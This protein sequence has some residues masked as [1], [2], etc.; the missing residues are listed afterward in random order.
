VRPASIKTIA[1]RVGYSRNTVSLALRNDRRVTDDTRQRVLTAA[2]ELNYRPNL[3]ARA[4]VTGRSQMLGLAIPRLDFSYMPRLVESIQEAAFE[5]GYGV[6]SCSHHNERHRLPELLSYL[7]DRQVEGVIVYC[8]T[9][10]ETDIAHDLVFPAA[11]TPLVSF[12]FGPQR[13]RGLELDLLP[14]AAGEMAVRHFV[15]RG[16]TTIGYC[17][18]TDGFFGAARLA[19]VRR[20]LTRRKLKPPAVFD[21]RDSIDGGREAARLFLDTP[22]HVARDRPTAVV[23]FTDGVAVGFI[24]ELRRRGLSVPD[25]VSV[26]GTDD[27]PVSEACPPGLTTLR[28]PTE[29]M[30]R[31]AVESL[32]AGG[33]V[34]CERRPFEWTLVERQSVADR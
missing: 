3:L 26:I 18:E 8:P 4:M 9:P 6:L 12:G 15:Q 5:N 20:A 13:R 21:C 24:L 16:H 14:G 10:P 31:S 22:T 33:G 30:G 25:D 2:K 32:L 1:E 19:G 27:L 7:Q 23:A 11:K 28:A 17:G 29:L 34:K